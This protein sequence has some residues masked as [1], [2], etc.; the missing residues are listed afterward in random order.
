LSY[1]GAPQNA[2]SRCEFSEAK[3]SS[4]TVSTHCLFYQFLRFGSF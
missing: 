1:L 4:G 3:F 2:I